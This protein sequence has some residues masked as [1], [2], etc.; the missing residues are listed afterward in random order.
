MAGA[1]E[2]H[3]PPGRKGKGDRKHV[4]YARRASA[5]K[6]LVVKAGSPVIHCLLKINRLDSLI[7]LRDRGALRAKPPPVIAAN[8][9]RHLT[10]LKSPLRPRP[11]SGAPP[12]R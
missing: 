11:S 3:H 8:G 2:A 10:L 1:R 5:G 9:K 7:H 4:R 6:R 12:T